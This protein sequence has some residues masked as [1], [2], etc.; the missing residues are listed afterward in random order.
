[1]ISKFPLSFPKLIRK[2]QHNI[3]IGQYSS[4]LICLYLYKSEIGRWRKNPIKFGL[5]ISYSKCMRQTCFRFWICGGGFWNMCIDFISQA[6]LIWK[7]EVPNAPK[8]ETF[9]ELTWWCSKVLDF[10]LFLISDLWN[11][12]V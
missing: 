5:S 12:V 8:L 7:S 3:S 4:E 9:W 6:F 11:R 10:G 2:M 1:M